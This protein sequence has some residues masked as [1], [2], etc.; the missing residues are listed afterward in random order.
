M[1]LT[2]CAVGGDDGSVP[3]AGGAGAGTAADL[4]VSHVH[5]LD[6][7]PADPSRVFVA[8]HDGLLRFEEGQGLER[9][10][11][12]RSDFMG[13]AVGPDGVLLA[14]GHPAPE[15][16][17]PFALGLIR[18]TDGGSTWDPAALSGE[19]DLHAMDAGEGAVVGYDAAT[20]VL[21][22]SDDGKTFEDIDAGTGYIDVAAASE[23]GRVLATTAEAG[24]VQSDDG[25]RTFA[26]VAGAPQLV[27]VD[28]APDGAVIGVGID[29]A[30]HTSSGTGE[31]QQREGSADEGLQAFTTGPDGAVW[32]LD[33][34]GLLRSS[35]SGDSFLPAGG[36]QS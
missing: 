14:S 15:E 20:G 29:G 1:T 8:T 4:D 30:I 31:W 10:G 19:A 27:L 24:L 23:G 17:G 25:G 36:W 35:D 21:R 28:I 5:A 34:R 18:S 32:L 2:A 6:V 26:P 13:F 22:V 16:D 11:D 9:I 33:S 3:N 7:D 12:I